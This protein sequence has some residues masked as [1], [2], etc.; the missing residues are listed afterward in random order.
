MTHGTT[1]LSTSG[2]QGSRLIQK[3]REATLCALFYQTT[4]RGFHAPEYQTRAHLERSLR[5]EVN[6]GA[7]T[8]T[9]SY[10]GYGKRQMVQVS[11][12]KGE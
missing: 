12:N 11:Q 3:A 7:G 8:A 2:E 1:S 5:D 6:S 9:T 4:S 10:N